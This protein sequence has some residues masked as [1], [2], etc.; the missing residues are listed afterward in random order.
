MH[1]T[2][3]MTVADGVTTSLS[4]DH[5]G[6]RERL[7]RAADGASAQ[8]VR[9]ARADFRAF[10][11]AFERHVRAEE[12]VLFPLF[13]VRVGLIGGPTVLMRDEHR[14]MADQVRAMAGALDR[15]DPVTFGE[16]QAL[17]NDLF[18]AHTSRE[19]RFLYMT[20]DRL[21]SSEQRAALGERLR[22]P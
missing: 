17:F 5:D 11:A 14:R 6:L 4:R 8:R 10:Q 22:H 21:L 9:Q 20:L 12:E 18:R 13:E 19:E 7:R 3:P 15:D 1:A 2:L 16:L